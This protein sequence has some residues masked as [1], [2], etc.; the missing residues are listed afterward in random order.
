MFSVDDQE[1]FFRNKQRIHQ[2][3]QSG[4]Y[5]ANQSQW[6]IFLKS[7]RKRIYLTNGKVY[8]DP[9]PTNNLFVYSQASGDWERQPEAAEKISGD[10]SRQESTDEPRE[11]WA[12]Q[13]PLSIEYRVQSEEF[14]L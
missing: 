7:D 2:Y 13:E 4:K 11:S 12:R 14:A 6:S 10:L 5:L 9:K 8:S 1:R 3:K